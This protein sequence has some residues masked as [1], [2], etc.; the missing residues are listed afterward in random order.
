MSSTSPDEPD[1]DLYRSFLHVLREGSLSGAARALGTTQPTIGRRLEAL[2]AALGCTLFIRTPT[3]LQATDTARRLAA[4]AEA[5]AAQAGALRRA[6]S[7]GQD[8]IAGTVRLTASETIGGEVLPPILAELQAAHPAIR[9][10]LAL[11]K[12]NEDLLQR[13][14]DIA[15]RMVRPSQEALVARRIGTLV[16]GLYAH[17]RYAE[18]RGLPSVID[19]LDGHA[20]IG[21]DRDAGALRA[22]QQSGLPLTPEG[23]AFRCDSEHAQHAALLAGLGIGACQSGIAARHPALLPV[24]P[25]QVR[26]ELEMWLAMHEDLRNEPRIRRVFDFLADGL[27][28]YARG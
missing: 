20:L 6:A 12:R 15:V 19:E 2:E 7:A 17:R 9:I 28:R 14:A 21:F 25:G 8:E 24:L 4:P 1:W 10:E 11:T 27:E 3:G 16:I 5:M 13:E 26:F 18:R 22:L 23:F